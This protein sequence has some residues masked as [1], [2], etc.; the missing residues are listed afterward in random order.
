MAQNPHYVLCHVAFVR[1]YNFPSYA[2]HCD[3]E[4]IP[5]FLFDDRTLWSKK[6]YVNIFFPRR[7]KT[8]E[9]S[10]ATLQ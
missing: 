3:V 7:L 5:G 2:I 8:I 6:V 4:R 1:N 9:D 10:E